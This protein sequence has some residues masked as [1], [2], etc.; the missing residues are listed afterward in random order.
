MLGWLH[1]DDIEDM[2]YR[3]HV[4]HLACIAGDRPHVVPISFAYEGGA[5]YGQAGPGRLLGAMR[6]RPE[7]SLEIAEHPEP[8]IW[9]SV[10]V[11]AMFEELAGDEAAG[12]ARLLQDRAAPIV[13]RDDEDVVAFRLR[14]TS[15][16]GR[17]AQ[18]E[19][20]H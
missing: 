15:R 12:A 16:S 13:H 17:W 5:I 2:L 7:V 4:G 8:T 20:R 18:T 14:V 6:A 11:E 9:R 3:H 19:R 1:P 10:V